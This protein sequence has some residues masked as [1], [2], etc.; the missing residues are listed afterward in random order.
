MTDERTIDGLI[1]ALLEAET[2]EQIIGC[3]NEL[4]TAWMG[5]QA[6]GAQQEAQVAMLRERLQ[7]VLAL[8]P[9]EAFDVVNEIRKMAFV[10]L[11]ATESTAAKYRRQ[12]EN[13]TLERAALHFDEMNSYADLSASIVVNA[14]RALKG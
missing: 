1:D 12:I 11:D 14:I 13:D 3:R 6:R 10:A 9:R 2:A 7:D 4:L 8:D 5:W